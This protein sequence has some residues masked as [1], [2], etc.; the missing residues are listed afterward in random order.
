[1][2][3]CV[4]AN[5]KMKNSVLEKYYDENCIH[6]CVYS[7]WGIFNDCITTAV[8]ERLWKMNDEMPCLWPNRRW[9]S[10]ILRLM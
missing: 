8:R 10:N 2:C 3:D 9:A 4:C 6:M 1:M 5:I 7:L